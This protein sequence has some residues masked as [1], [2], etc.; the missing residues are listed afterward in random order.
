MGVN[1]LTDL[2]H[3]REGGGGGGGQDKGRENSKVYVNLSC[4]NITLILIFCNILLT[5]KR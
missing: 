2:I 3:R 5:L 4:S 1:I